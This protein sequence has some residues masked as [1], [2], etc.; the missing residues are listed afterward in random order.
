MN[1]PQDLRKWA[2][3]NNVNHKQLKN[4]LS[5]LQPY[6]P[7]LAKDSRTLLHTL[8]EIHTSPMISAKGNFGKF[9][10]F[11]ILD[12]LE[13]E[14]QKGS[15]NLLKSKNTNVVDIIL[16]VDGIPIYKS[17][18]TQ[19][20]PIS[21][22]IYMQGQKNNVFDVGIYVGDSKPQNVSEFINDC[23]SE[24]NKL[25][26]DGFYFNNEKFI[27]KLKAVSCDAPAR[28]YLK[29]IKSHNSQDGCE[30][31]TIQAKRV[32][33]RIL[34]LSRDNELAQIRTHETFKN[35]SNKSHHVGVSPLLSV[36]HFDIIHGFRLDY[37]HMAC[38]GTMR[39]LLNHWFKSDSKVSI[40]PRFRKAASTRMENLLLPKEFNRK[41][42]SFLKLDRFKATEYRTLL[43]YT[44]PFVLKDLIPPNQYK[45]LLLLFCSMRICCNGEYLTKYGNL[46]IEFTERFVRQSEVLYEGLE[47]IYNTHSLIHMVRNAIL[48]GESL[49]EIN[50]FAF[51]NHLGQLKKLIRNSSHPLEQV[52]KRR[53]EKQLL[54][55]EISIDQFDEI[56]KIPNVIPD[57]KSDKYVLLTNNKV[58]AVTSISNKDNVCYLN[59]H[60]F[61]SVANV[62][63]SPIS[64]D[65]VGVWLVKNL[66]THI[67]EVP[68][69][70]YCSKCLLIQ[71]GEDL[72]VL[73]LLN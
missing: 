27:V 54:N 2:I 21:C 6:H 33:N 72:Y 19:F 63:Q 51:E 56:N 40:L 68:V 62:F 64:S 23:V 57:S 60:I 24:I 7:S 49:E 12:S 37:M 14:L 50:C 1:L 73:R 26:S 20:W 36:K 44:A 42:R 65:M 47:P 52:I 38:L 30:F 66:S 45:H 18:S 39:R 25:N 31:C 8:R 35:Q 10:Y 29:N 70:D 61:Q 32:N 71:V 9:V 15:Y 67:F 41:P 3:E 17:S 16:N 11:G 58:M 22:I 5:I 4:L 53:H 55:K 59:G 43:L 13:R 34:Y 69:K 28:A 46:A 48:N